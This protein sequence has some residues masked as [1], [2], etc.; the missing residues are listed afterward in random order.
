MSQAWRQM[1]S[2]SVAAATARKS[3]RAKSVPTEWQGQVAVVDWA[4][5]LTISVNGEPKRLGEYLYAVPNGSMLG[6]DARLR[7]IQVGRLK[8]AGMRPGVL[9]L[10]LDLP[11]G[12]FHGLRLEMKRHGGRPSPEQREWL[13]RLRSVGFDAHVAEG[14]EVAITIIQ[15]YLAQGPSRMPGCT[16][17]PR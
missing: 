5:R 3:A 10:V 6:G 1:Q 2:A 7:A 9:D 16:S 11:R 12:S 15:A 17:L 14:A 8:R 4:D 13:A